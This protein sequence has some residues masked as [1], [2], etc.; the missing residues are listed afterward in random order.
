[1]IC[2]QFWAS[3]KGLSFPGFSCAF[4]HLALFVLKGPSTK[5]QKVKPLA[6]ELQPA[7]LRGNYLYF[8]LEF[9]KANPSRGFGSWVLGIVGKK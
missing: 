2:W 1:M 5:S 7:K 9:C 6:G 4:R 8:L 3:L